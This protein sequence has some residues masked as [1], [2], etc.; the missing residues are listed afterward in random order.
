MIIISTLKEIPKADY[1][2]VSVKTDISQTVAIIDS[3]YGCD[4]D[5]FKDLGGFCCVISTKSDV[6]YLLDKWNIDIVNDI[7][8]MTLKIDEYIKKL[9]ILNSDYCIITYI[10]KNLIK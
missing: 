9:F 8:E 10:N 4:R 5:I 7:C 2:P 1:L 6:K 3:A